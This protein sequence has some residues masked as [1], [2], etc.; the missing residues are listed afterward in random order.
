[1]GN[2]H[3]ILLVVLLWMASAHSLRCH[4]CHSES[5]DCQNPVECKPN[6]LACFSNYKEITNGSETIRSTV[7]N[8]TANC[9]HCESEPT[10]VTSFFLSSMCC[11]K[12][13][14]NWANSGSSSFGVGVLG[15][16]ISL[17]CTLLRI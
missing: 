7:K 12:D 15:T 13:L 14:C 4:V 3:I 1:M 11:N 5:S 16:V 2:F 8:C 6:E 9:D 17:T 10:P